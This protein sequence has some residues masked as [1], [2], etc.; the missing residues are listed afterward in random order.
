MENRADPDVTV[1]YDPSHL[2]LHC[3]KSICFDLEM[4]GLNAPRQNGWHT[5]LHHGFCKNIND[6]TVTKH[7]SQ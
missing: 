6:A 2:D 5:F 3:L 7:I 4:K 1:R